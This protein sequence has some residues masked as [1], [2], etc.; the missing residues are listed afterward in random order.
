MSFKK[1]SGIFIKWT[2]WQKCPLYG[3][4]LFVEIP[5]NN[6]KKVSEVNMKST[7]CHEFLSPYLLEGPKDGKV[8]ENAKFF[9]F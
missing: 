3:D 6:Q 5:S 4:V 1:H 8:K 7:I 2:P 9:S